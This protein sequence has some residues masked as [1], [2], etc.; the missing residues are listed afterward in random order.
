MSHELPSNHTRIS[1]YLDTLLVEHSCWDEKLVLATESP[2]VISR[3]SMNIRPLDTVE[4]GHYLL[5]TGPF[6]MGSHSEKHTHLL[7]GLSLLSA[8]P[9]SRLKT[10]VLYHCLPLAA[11]A[12]LC[13]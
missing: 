12:M 8:L 3:L 9:P 1:G 11:E 5:T 4:K 7:E 10:T 6:G 13:D 2:Q